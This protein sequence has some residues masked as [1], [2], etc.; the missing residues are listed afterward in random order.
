[1]TACTCGSGGHPRRCTQHPKAYD[2][3]VAELNEEAFKEKVTRAEGL[4]HG[5]F[6]LCPVS[7]RIIESADAGDDKVICFCRSARAV[8]GTHY[9]SGLKKATA[10]DYVRQRE[11]DLR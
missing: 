9:K 3:H 11:E 1:L 2:E 7:N 8:G 4:W 10:E 5:E 6:Y